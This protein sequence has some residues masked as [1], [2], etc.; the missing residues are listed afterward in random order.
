ME[1]GGERGYTT[2]AHTTY[3]RWQGGRGRKGL[4]VWQ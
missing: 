1:G 4:E 2:H 3:I